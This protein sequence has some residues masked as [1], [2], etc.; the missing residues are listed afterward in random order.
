MLKENLTT[1]LVL[2]YPDFTREFLVTTNTSDYAIGA[3]L[4][5]GH[6]GQDRPIRQPRINQSGTELQHDRKRITSG[7]VGSKIFSPVPVWRKIQNNHRSST[8]D[9][10]IQ[11]RRS[12][13]E[14]DRWRLKLQEY[15]YEIVHKAGKRN[16]NADAL[17]RN[18][19]G[20]DT[21][22]NSLD[23]EVESNKE[24]PKREYTTEEKRQILY[25]FHDAP[26][27]GHQ[28]VTRT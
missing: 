21:H 7:R 26:L 10:A 12:G 3:V 16:T 4:S 17:S 15:D 13:L 18:P 6:I 1:A 14:T 9:L 8:I 11:E 24:A 5:Q 20:S 25:E 2:S 22:I 28:G 23:G 27:G 19:T